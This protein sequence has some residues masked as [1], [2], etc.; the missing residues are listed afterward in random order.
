YAGESSVTAPGRA[1]TGAKVGRLAT[2]PS[3]DDLTGRSQS[4][5]ALDPEMIKQGRLTKEARV[6]LR[7][8]ESTTLPNGAKVTFD[9]AKEFV[10]LQVSHDPAQQWVLVSALTMMA[11]LLVSLL[12]KR[13]R[14]WIRAYPAES[15]AGTVDQRRTVVEMGGLAR[16]DQAGWGGEFDRLRARVLDAETEN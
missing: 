11:G 4:L 5:F 12:V 3:P 1:P 14:I 15:G 10:N 9:G 2:R 8:G 16:S 7:P 6:N 13:R